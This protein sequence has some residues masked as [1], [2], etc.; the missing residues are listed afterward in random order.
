M[1]N[2]VAIFGAGAATAILCLYL[3]DEYR[4]RRRFEKGFGKAIR[5][6]GEIWKKYEEEERRKNAGNN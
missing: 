1:D 2:K 4:T 5:H 6:A 3:F